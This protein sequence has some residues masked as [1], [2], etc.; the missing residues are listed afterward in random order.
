MAL[1]KSDHFLGLP[2]CETVTKTTIQSSQ[3]LDAQTRR[4]CLTLE[5]LGRSILNAESMI[6]RGYLCSSSKRVEE[7]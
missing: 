7:A 1:L 2:P 3:S 6:K 4:D 5:D